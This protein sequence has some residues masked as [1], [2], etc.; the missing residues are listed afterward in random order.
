MTNSS[1][2]DVLERIASAIDEARKVFARFTPGEIQ[3]EYKAGHDP[4]TE[5]DRALDA[6]LRKNLL[7]PGEGWLSEESADDLSR[8]DRERV[9][10]V[11]PLDGTREFVEG[12]PEFCVS[13]AMVE[14]GRAV[15]GGICNPATNE[16]FL[17][18]MYSGLTYNGVPTQTSQRSNLDGAV[19]LASRSETKRGEWQPFHGAPF[20]V[21]P[22]GS[23]AYKLARVSAGLADATFTLT[24]KHE[25]DVAGGA[26][27]LLSAGGSVRTLEDSDLICNRKDPLLSGL[28]ACG[29]HLNPELMKFLSSYLQPTA[30]K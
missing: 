4:V 11:D 6:V 14:H 7:R 19:V 29:E 17:G 25:W 10:V 20:K 13:I 30:K 26:A 9:W 15:A 3:A 16:V 21:V 24:P 18:S 1:Y 28:I 12:I 23:V 22:M 27:L 5:A 2:T 8:L